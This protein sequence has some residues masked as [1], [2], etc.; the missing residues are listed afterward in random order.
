MNWQEM[1]DN[2]LK[3]MECCGYMEKPNCRD[4]PQDGPGFGF[5]CREMLMRSAHDLIAALDVTPDELKRLKKCRHEC[6][7]D[8]LLEKHDDLIEKHNSMIDKASAFIDNLITCLHAIEYH[9]I[10]FQLDY[11]KRML[12]YNRIGEGN[13]NGTV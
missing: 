7:I 5:A 12:N 1:R 10:E 8:C 4:C 13:N 2:T 6:K 9:E 11:L 3:G